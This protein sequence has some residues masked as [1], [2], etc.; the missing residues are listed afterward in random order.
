MLLMRLKSMNK[1]SNLKNKVKSQLKNRKK[2][3]K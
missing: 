2:M 3:E 1:A